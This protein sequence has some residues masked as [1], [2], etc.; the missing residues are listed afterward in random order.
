[1][2][3]EKLHKDTIAKLQEMVNSG[4]ITVETARGICADFVPE[5]EDEKVRKEII[6]HIQYCDDTIDEV[7]EKRMIAWLEKQCQTFT[8]KDVDDAYLKGVRDA[9]HELEKRGE[10]KPVD[11]GEFNLLTV[12]RAK[13][14]SPFMRSGFEQNHVWSEEDERLRNSC[15][16]HIEEELERIRNDKY[17]HSEIIS[18]LKESCRERINWLKSIRP[19]TTWKP[20]DEQIKALDFAIDCTVYPEFNIQRSVLKELLKQLKKLREG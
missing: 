19:Q 10:Q 7:A 2:D 8:K 1:M 17:G 12:E 6:Y 14:I 9:K 13:G 11:N 5:S 15:I 18:D 20:S 4:K 16:S 3:Y